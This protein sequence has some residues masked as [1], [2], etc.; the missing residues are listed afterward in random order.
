MWSWSFRSF[1]AYTFL[2]IYL[3]MLVYNIMVKWQTG[4]IPAVDWKLMCWF[5]SQFCKQPK[6]WCTCDHPSGSEVCESNKTWGSGR[7]DY[8]P[9]SSWEKESAAKRPLLANHFMGGSLLGLL[10]PQTWP[11]F[12]CIELWFALQSAQDKEIKGKS[13]DHC[14]YRACQL[15]L[16]IHTYLLILWVRDTI[17]DAK[18]SNGSDGSKVKAT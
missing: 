1:S 17:Q 9:R 12:V 8:S 7:V 5:Y 2:C 10:W 11:A 3:K 6:I 18:R 13:G 16:D 15:L 4:F 14:R